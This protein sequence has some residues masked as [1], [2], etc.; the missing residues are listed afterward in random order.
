MVLSSFLFPFYFSQNTTDTAQERFFLKITD[1][2]IVSFVVA[3]DVVF[4][5]TQMLIV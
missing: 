3:T 1:F 5:S 4:S 2:S